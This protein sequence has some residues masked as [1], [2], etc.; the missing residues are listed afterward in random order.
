MSDASAPRH[1]LDP[2][3]RI[4]ETLF[5]LIMALTFICSLSIASGAG[6]NIR[7]MLMGALGCN[8]A[9]GIVDG[10]L[11]LLARINDR[12]DKALTL[13]AIRQAPDPETA[14]RIISDALPPQLAAI[15]PLD[16]L[17]VLRKTLQQLPEPFLDPGL[18]KRDWT[19]ALGLCLLSFLST[20]PLTIP[21]V[22]L[23]D[24]RLAL[25]VTYVVAIVMLFCCGYVFGLRS[26]LRPWMA[27]L[28][29]VAVGCALVGVAVALGG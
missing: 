21:S 11:Y 29:M 1:V 20:L 28:S 9:W 7:T 5:G 15:L 19:G 4:S 22:L 18:T 3:E 2:M 26:G 16:Q 6:I 8:L 10:G 12:G 23:R 24:P 25:H 13:R 27:G 17:E 14:Q